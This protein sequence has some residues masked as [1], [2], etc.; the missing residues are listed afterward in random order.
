MDHGLDASLEQAQQGNHDAFRLLMEHHARAVYRVAYRMT[1]NQHDAED[2]TQET[3][4]RAWKYLG[5]FDGRAS[6]ATWLYRI[7][8]NCALDH[9]GSK[10]RRPA[11]SSY[12]GTDDEDIFQR[13]ASPEPSPERV[14]SSSEVA[15]LLA[16]ALEELS[17]MERVAF[18]MRH[19]EC[20]SVETIVESLCIREGASIHSIFRSVQTIR[21]AMASAWSIR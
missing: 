10:G 4:L 12:P 3:F 9:H 2:L 15:A 7:C 21:R 14:A 16:P 1:G 6:F 8:S 18:V 5:R 20:A 11:A 13:V 19:Y 17:G